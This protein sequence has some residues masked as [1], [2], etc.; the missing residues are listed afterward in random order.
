VYELEIIR[1]PG[2]QRV[3]LYRSVKADIM[4]LKKVIIIREMYYELKKA[5]DERF[6]VDERKRCQPSGLTMR[7]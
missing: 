6:V 4:T 5:T 3:Y 1:N 7:A 2:N